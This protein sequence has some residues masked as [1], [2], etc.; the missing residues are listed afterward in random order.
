MDLPALL[1]D[2]PEALQEPG[3][4]V[5]TCVCNAPSV[6]ATFW[7]AV[8]CCPL[9]VAPL[10]TSGILT[11]EVISGRAGWS[12]PVSGVSTLLGC[13]SDPPVGCKLSIA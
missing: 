9:S 6:G 11:P 8:N 1:P 10:T 2:A 4:P 12:A 5:L 13:T 3:A 7:F